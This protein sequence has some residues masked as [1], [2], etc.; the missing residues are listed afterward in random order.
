M[1][2]VRLQDL[3]KGKTAIDDIREIS[4]NRS[5]NALSSMLG[6]PEKGP[7]RMLNMSFHDQ[8]D[9]TLKL[10]AGK[11]RTLGFPFVV[12]QQAPS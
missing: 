3:N 12:V 6:A 9:T 4:S 1:S 5:S 8:G 11:K 2:A 7:V 10:D